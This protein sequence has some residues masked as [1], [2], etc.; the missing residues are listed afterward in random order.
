[1]SPVRFPHH[2]PPLVSTQLTCC[3]C[4]DIVFAGDAPE[5]VNE[6]T[7]EYGPLKELGDRKV[8]ELLEKIGAGAPPSGGGQD[9]EVR[10]TSRLITC[11]HILIA[12]TLFFLGGAIARANQRAVVS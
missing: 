11:T 5:G 7:L 12:R 3:V 4:L 9:P 1:M 6:Q 2:P 10:S 8:R